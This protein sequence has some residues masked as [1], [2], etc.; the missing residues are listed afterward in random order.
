MPAHFSEYG[1][2]SRDDPQ[3]LDK[4]ETTTANPPFFTSSF[5]TAPSR[6]P[7]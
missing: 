6:I 1:A 5:C 2:V 4:P 3:P 7:T